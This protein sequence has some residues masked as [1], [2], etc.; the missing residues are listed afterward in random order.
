MGELRTWEREVARQ[1]IKLASS[2]RIPVHAIRKEADGLKVE[3]C[4][5]KI[6]QPG[7]Q[8]A[9]SSSSKNPLI[10]L[11]VGALLRRLIRYDIPFTTTNA[12]HH[13]DSLK[14]SM[15]TIFS[16]SFFSFLYLMKRKEENMAQ[17]EKKLGF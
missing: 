8:I 3:A 7:N 15:I 1:R 14:E 9:R 12:T 6:E 17:Q 5:P 11:D 13:P 2:R 16:T 4:S 10:I